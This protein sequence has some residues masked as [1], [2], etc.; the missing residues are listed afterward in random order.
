MRKKLAVLI[1]HGMGSQPDNFADGIIEE[2]QWRLKKAGKDP[3][4]VAWQPVWWAYATEPRQ[5]EY[6]ESAKNSNDLDFLRLRR[7]VISAVG[8]AAAYRQVDSEDNSTYKHIHDII[9]SKITNLYT[10]E[11]GGTPVPLVVL[12]HSLGSSIISNYIW[13]H[14]KSTTSSNL[15]PFQRMEWL[16]GI[17]TFGSTIPLFALAHKNPKPIRFPGKA[18][19]RRN[20]KEKAKWL[21]FFDPDDVLGYPLK[22]INKNYDRAVDK[23]I[24]INVG[25]IS[26]S[27]NPLSHNGYWTDNSFTKPVADF[28]ETLI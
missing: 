21:N 7:F 12:A 14:Q 17:I 8:D 25:G 13:D 22:P 5:N 10:D 26:T 18:I 2:L 6:F 19:V 1:L 4:K 15:T 27:W 24:E 9:D 11:L 20:M 28:L 23:D 16:A 3:E